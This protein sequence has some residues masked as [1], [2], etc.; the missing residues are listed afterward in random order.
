MIAPRGLL[1]AAL[2]LWG[3]STGHVALGGTFFYQITFSQAP[4]DTLTSTGGF[5]SFFAFYH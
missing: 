2:V 5:A 3:A 4:G 1:G